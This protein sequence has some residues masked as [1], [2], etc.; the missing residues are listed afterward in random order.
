MSPVLVVFVKE[1]R[2]SLRDKRV[3]LN[4]LILGPLFG[5]LLF[6]GLLRGCLGHCVLLRSDVFCHRIPSLRLKLV[7]GD[8]QCLGFGGVL[9][10]RMVTAALK[11]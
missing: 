5:P 11:D 6:V 9:C 3:L 2:E 7:K 8:L 4:A 10:T 1:C